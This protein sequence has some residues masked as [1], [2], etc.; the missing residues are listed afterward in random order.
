MMSLF[1]CIESAR[2]E[3]NVIDQDCTGTI[4]RLEFF[5]WFRNINARLQKQIDAESAA[6]KTDKG[7]LTDTDGGSDHDALAVLGHDVF[8][9]DEYYDSKLPPGEDGKRLRQI[10]RLLQQAM[11]VEYTV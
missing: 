7:D 9:L 11:L 10:P 4:D 3:F 6:S 5:S 8:D 2:E 1:E